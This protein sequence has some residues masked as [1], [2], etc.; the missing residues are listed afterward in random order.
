MI[1]LKNLHIGYNS[2]LLSINDMTL[3]RG[4][5]YILLGKNGSGKS[6]FLKTLSAQI[7]ARSGYCLID[8]T[9]ISDIS[10][11][12]LP[13]MISFV[14]SRL[15]DTDFMT[16]FDYICLGRSPYTNGFGSLHALDLVKINEAISLLNINHLS[17]RFINQLSDGERQLVAIAKSIAQETDILLLD[18]PTAFLDYTNKMMIID[19]LMEI[20]KE[21]NKC[22]ILSSHDLDLSIGTNC[23]FLIVNKHSVTIDLLDVSTTKEKLIELAY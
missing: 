19:R 1:K 13:K 18:E 7:P 16:A 2:D 22:V 15:E 20:A 9:A 5:V 23:P 3:E 11:K 8:E 14:S 6:T 4:K 12:E 21:L 17:D 10:V